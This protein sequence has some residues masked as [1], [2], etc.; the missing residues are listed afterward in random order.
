MEREDF[1]KDKF[2]FK[3]EIYEVAMRELKLS[4]KKQLD[5]A[6]MIAADAESRLVQVY[7]GGSEISKLL[8]LDICKN[9]TTMEEAMDVIA[10][11]RGALLTIVSDRNKLDGDLSALRTT[12]AEL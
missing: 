7:K 3:L 11:L 6:G 12:I 9:V 4:K 10:K 5:Q 2:Q 8:D 1:L